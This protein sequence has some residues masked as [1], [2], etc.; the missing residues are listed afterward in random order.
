MGKVGSLGL[1]VKHG[2][3]GGSRT[4]TRLPL[5]A[6]EASAYRQFRHPGISY[7]LDK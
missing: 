2:A 5:L 7:L 3:E 4:L 6:P 1:T